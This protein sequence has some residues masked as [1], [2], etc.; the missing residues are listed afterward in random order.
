M[1][2]P[3]PLLFVVPYAILLVWSVIRPHDYPTWLLEAFPALACAAILACTYRAFPLT[4]L[5]Y[6]CLLVHCALLFVGSHYT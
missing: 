2:S 6:A 5:V 4:P 3:K 1:K